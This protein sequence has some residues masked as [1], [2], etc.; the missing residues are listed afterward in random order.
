MGKVK[1]NIDALIKSIEETT[2]QAKHYQGIV[3][4]H[5][6]GEVD[7]CLSRDEAERLA[8]S[9]V[10]DLDPLSTL[11]NLTIDAMWDIDI[12]MYSSKREM[13]IR[14]NENRNRGKM[15]IETA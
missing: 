2:E 6:D 5:D 7:S 9:W 1:D 8:A 11:S 15:S 14:A 4:G 13:L 3:N 10:L 12:L